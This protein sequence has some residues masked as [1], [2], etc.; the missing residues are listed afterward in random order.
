MVTLT[1][2]S[3]R[4]IKTSNV[5]IYWGLAITAVVLL[6]LFLMM[7]I[8]NKEVVPNSNNLILPMTE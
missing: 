8:P 7:R 5:A 6:T 4:I 2:D 3:P 1:I